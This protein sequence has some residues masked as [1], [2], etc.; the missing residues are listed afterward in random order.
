MLCAHTINTNPK[1]PTVPLQNSDAKLTNL[2]ISRF[3]CATYGRW[4]VSTTVVVVFFIEVLLS[5]KDTD[6]IVSTQRCP[7]LCILTTW[8]LYDSNKFFTISDRWV[9]PASQHF[10]RGAFL[11]IPYKTSFIIK[12]RKYNLIFSITYLKVLYCDR[13]FLSK[14]C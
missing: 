2:P 11:L 1:T 14:A 7:F 4:L 9:V 10:V 13:I 5:S 8:V 12:T 6:Q 3:V